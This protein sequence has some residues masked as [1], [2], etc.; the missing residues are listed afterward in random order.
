MEW[1]AGGDKALVSKGRI[2]RK[3]ALSTKQVD[4]LAEILKAGA[5]AAGMPTE[6]WTLPRMAKVIRACFAQA[7][8]WPE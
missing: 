3:S 8:L 2:G 6:V 5:V 4:E 1:L 7:A